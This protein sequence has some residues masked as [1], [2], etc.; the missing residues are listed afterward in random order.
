M[1]Q[2]TYVVT[3]SFCSSPTLSTKAFATACN[4]VII[5]RHYH[6]VNYFN[7]MHLRTLHFNKEPLTLKGKGHDF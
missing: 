1:W 3:S 4:V 5:H 6:Y 2:V 7:S